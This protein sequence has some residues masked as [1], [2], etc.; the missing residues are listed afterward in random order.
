MKDNKWSVWELQKLSP[1]KFAK[2]ICSPNFTLKPLREKKIPKE[3]N[4]TK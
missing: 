1:E 4:A 2:V 3:L